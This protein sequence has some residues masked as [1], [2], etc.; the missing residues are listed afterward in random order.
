L[1]HLVRISGL[2]LNQL[3][4]ALKKRTAVI[5]RILKGDAEVVKKIESSPPYDEDVK[6]ICQ[7]QL[8]LKLL[9]PAEKD[10]VVIKY[11]SGMSMTAIANLY[12]CHRTTVSS[13]LKARGVVIRE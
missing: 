4:Y 6:V 2:Y 8:S 12:G 5:K 7:H 13:I 1:R 11:Q 3:H 10:E 9:T